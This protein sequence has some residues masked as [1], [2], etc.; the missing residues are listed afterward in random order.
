MPCWAALR[1]KMLASNSSQARITL[2]GYMTGMH[3]ACKQS[4]DVQSVMQAG[5]ARWRSPNAESRYCSWARRCSCTAAVSCGWAATCRKKG[6]YSSSVCASSCA[7]SC[8]VAVICVLV[9]G[10]SDC[11]KLHTELLH[12]FTMLAPAKA[13]TLHAVVLLQRSQLYTACRSCFPGDSQ[14]YAVLRCCGACT[15]STT[16]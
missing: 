4:S 9:M 3:Q 5:R 13:L 11:R 14:S 10:F 1:Y 7:C 12:C 16:T 8:C 2:R 15:G 6:S